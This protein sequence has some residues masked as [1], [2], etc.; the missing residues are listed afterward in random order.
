MTAYKFL[1]PGAVGPFTGF[2]WPLPG[3]GGGAWVEAP[4]GAGPARWVHACRVAD[5]PYWFADELWSVELDAQDAQVRE[6][7]RQLAAPRARLVEHVAGWDAAAGRALA[8]ACAW[9]T[10]EL[11]VVRLAPA[12]GAELAAA[13]DLASLEAAAREAG[14]RPEAAYVATAVHYARAGVAATAAFVAASLAAASGGVEAFHAERA[15][16]ARW[17]AGRLRLRS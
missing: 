16:Q 6:S 15:W 9:R 3:A 5:L 13:Q 14:R 8:E 10:R 4:P 17:L 1:A 11:A 2:R 12:A 7:E